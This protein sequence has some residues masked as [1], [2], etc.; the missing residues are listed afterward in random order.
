MYRSASREKFDNADQSPNLPA[1]P[2]GAWNPF[3]TGALTGALRWNAQA[4]EGFRTA[5]SEWQIFLGRR[6]EDDF[7]LVQRLT[8]SR[9]PDQIWA[10]YTDFWQKAVE[11]YGKEITA[12][13]K[14]M[15][16]VAGKMETVA[17][18]ATGEPGSVE[19]PWKKAA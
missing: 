9:T 12:L 1:L 11:D 7:A 10:A 18:S 19:T 13:T 4:H 17:Q 15:T 3:L 16:A 6:L 14:L 5:V 8:S 2:F